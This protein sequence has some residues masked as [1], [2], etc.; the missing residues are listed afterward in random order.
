MIL[1]VNGKEYILEDISTS[2]ELHVIAGTPEN[3]VEIFQELRAMQAYIYNDILYTDRAVSKIT[4]SEIRD[5][6]VKVVVRLRP[7]FAGE[8]VSQELQAA[9]AELD[10]LKEL[11]AEQQIAAKESEVI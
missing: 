5:G 3:G 8:L 11:V 10:S 4:L 9:R 7:M 1:N 6:D 2:T